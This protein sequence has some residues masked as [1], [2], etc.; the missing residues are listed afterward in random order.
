MIYFNSD[1]LEGAHPDVLRRL[2]ETNMVQ[3]IGY[4]C[5]EYCAAAREKIRQ[6][7]RLPEGDVHFLIAGTQTNTTVIAAALRPYQGVIAAASGHIN[8]H[9]SGAIESAG[10][11][12]IALDAPDGKITAAQVA[13]Y[14]HWH[15]NDESMEHIVYPGMVYIS[16]PTECGTLYTK[17]ELTA[18]Y[19]TCRELGLYL[20]VDGARLGYGLTSD[21][22]DLTLP[23]LAR[24]CDVFYI[25]GTKVGALFGEAVVIV[26]ESLKKDFRP[27]EKQR[28]AMLAKGRLLGVQFEAL[29]TDELYFRIAR[30][31]NEMAAQIRDLFIKAGYPLLFASPT[32]QQYPILPDSALRLLGKD[33]GFDYWT[34]VDR[35]HSA[36][37]FAA[38]WA[39][40]QEQVDALRRAVESLPSA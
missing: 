26:N 7:C 21:A 28:G 4:G 37:R 40:T 11:K 23:E 36:V 5:D 38:G 9:E 30:H 22:C 3:T 18:L 14:V 10:H 20:Y 32:N 19:D 33:F 15:R 2:V 29:F 27:V 16:Y 8:C 24:L 12:V 6:V 1:Y 39:T 34:R 13:E 25:G 35:E 17:A 31:A